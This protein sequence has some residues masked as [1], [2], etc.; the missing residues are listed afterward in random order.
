M[1]FTQSYLNQVSI[2]TQKLDSNSIEEM[3]EG[4]VELRKEGGRLFFI[5]IGGSASNASHCVNDFRKICGIECYTPTDNV[6]E[7]SARINDEGWEGSFANFLRGS[8][9]NQKDG[10]FVLSVGGGNIEKNISLNIVAAL[11]YAREVKAKIFGVVGRD[12]GFTKKVADRCVVVPTVDPSLVT[13]HVE[14]FQSVICHL[15]AAHPKMKNN[16]TKWES[17]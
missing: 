7:F 10:V 6:S 16:Q 9:L 8:M 1:A 11:H 3:I 14:S 13:F 17:V 15:I 5:G 12:G 2:I 4:L